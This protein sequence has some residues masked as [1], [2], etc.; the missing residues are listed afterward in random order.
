M[1][2]VRLSE[3]AAVI[4]AQRQVPG[5]MGC[6][7]SPPPRPG[8][9][10]AAPLPHVSYHF[11]A[12]VVAGRGKS[13]AAHQ[14]RPASR[15]CGRLAAPPENTAPTARGD[16]A[17]GR[18]GRTAFIPACCCAAVAGGA[19]IGRCEGML[20]RSGGSMGARTG[21]V[22]AAAAGLG[23]RAGGGLGGWTGAGRTGR[24]RWRGAGA[25]LLHA[26][27]GDCRHSPARLAARVIP[28]VP[29]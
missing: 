24:D 25:D 6:R 5:R 26:G 23:R 10:A 16:R 22:L 2:V 28:D 7:T 27:N 21:T 20:G 29:V 13:F 19:I 17:T 3:L 11:R 15:R 9:V 12:G 8:I 14:W 18:A 4:V 1:R